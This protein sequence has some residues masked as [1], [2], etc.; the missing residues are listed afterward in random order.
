MTT[1]SSSSPNVGPADCAHRVRHRNPEV[2]RKPKAESVHG[3]VREEPIVRRGLI[4][5]RVKLSPLSTSTI[6]YPAGAASGLSG[7][8]VS[9]QLMAVR[10]SLTERFDAV[11][12]A[13]DLDRVRVSS[14]L[15]SARRVTLGQFLT[16]YGVAQQMSRGRP[17]SG[18]PST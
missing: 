6:R 14:S 11:L 8:A 15:D 7:V 18:V 4:G 2:P 17:R 12:A 13:I 3:G 10:S 9:L 1:R 16:P 5:P